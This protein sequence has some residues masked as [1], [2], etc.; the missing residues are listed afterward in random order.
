MT[1]QRSPLALRVLVVDDVADARASLRMLLTLW[2]HGSREAA[3]GAAALRV[4]ADFGPDV[5]LIDLGLPAMSG[6]ELAV[7]L[8]ELPGL[9]RCRLVAVSEHGLEEDLER[10]RSAGFEQHFLKPPDVAALEAYL[11][12][13]A[14]APPAWR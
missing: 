11:G 9:G 2:G 1:G 10:C 3:D 6:L 7:R 12:A 13:A 5:A 4:A 14:G 8:R